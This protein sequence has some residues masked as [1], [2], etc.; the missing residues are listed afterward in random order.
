MAVMM[1]AQWQLFRQLYELY[2]ARGG[3]PIPIAAKLEASVPR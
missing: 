3:E 2:L 1:F